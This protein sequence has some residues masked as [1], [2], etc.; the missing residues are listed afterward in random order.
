MSEPLSYE[1]IDLA[2]HPP[3]GWSAELWRKVFT[4]A[5]QMTRQELIVAWLDASADAL[6]EEA[7]NQELQ[8]LAAMSRQE[9]IDLIN[10]IG[11]EGGKR[12]LRRYGHYLPP[13]PNRPR[14]F[15]V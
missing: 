15:V 7:F 3:K 14:Q 6:E 12:L 11:P 4:V 9:L 8:S 10:E 13:V 2:L 1:P 5:N